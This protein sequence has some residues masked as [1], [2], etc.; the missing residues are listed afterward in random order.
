MLHIILKKYFLLIILWI[1][2]NAPQ[3]HSSPHPSISVLSP[4]NLP[5]K[6]SKQTKNKTKQQLKSSCN[7][8]CSVSS[9]SFTCGCSFQWVTELVRGLCL[10]LCY[11][12]WTLPSTPLRVLLSCVLETLQLCFCRPGPFTCSSSSWI[13]LDRVELGS[14]NSK[15]SVWAWMVPELVRYNCSPT[16]LRWREGPSLHH[17]HLSKQAR[18]R[19]SFPTGQ[20]LLCWL[21]RWCT[22][23]LF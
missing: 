19:A 8:S 21:P 22:V 6:E 4:C 15:P 10:L 11:Q 9:H 23:P 2:Q 12:Y 7:G 14:T 18:A 3:S 13:E 16:L 17:P 20:G 5:P 1:S